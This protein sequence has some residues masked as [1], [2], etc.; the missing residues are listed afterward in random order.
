[1]ISVTTS[2]SPSMQAKRE[3]SLDKQNY[4]EMLARSQSEELAPSN[5]KQDKES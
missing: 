5:P 4:E 1:M 2:L 3:T